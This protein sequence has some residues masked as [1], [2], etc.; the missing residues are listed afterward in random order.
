MQ[1]HL[2]TPEETIAFGRKLAKELPKQSVICFSGDLGAG[3]T[4]LIKGLV[5]GALDYPEEQVSSP[6][7]VYLHIYEGK[8]DKKVCH[9]DLY[10][11]QDSE[12][13]FTMGFDEYCGTET[14][15]CIE[16]PE[17]IKGAIP[18]NAIWITLSGTD[19]GGR[20]AQIH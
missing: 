13:F 6:T 14:L 15:T 16:W 7:F 10:R 8:E 9:F 2:Q 4:T 20:L 1:V 11:L 12:E 19:E 3:K 17:R 5:A 18:K